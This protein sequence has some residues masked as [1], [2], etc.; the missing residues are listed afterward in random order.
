MDAQLTTTCDLLRLILKMFV[1][2]THIVNYRLNLYLII[3][4]QSGKAL[5]LSSSHQQKEPVLDA[6]LDTSKSMSGG[7]TT[8][9]AISN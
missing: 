4:G 3:F 7:T 9:L 6:S 1:Y 5:S 2:R 8:N